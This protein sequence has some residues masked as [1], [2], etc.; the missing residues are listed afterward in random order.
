MNIWKRIKQLS[1]GQL[2][3]LTVVFVQRPLLI[4]PT[5]RATKRTMHIC[6][7]MYGRTHHKNGKANAF[8]HALWNILICQNS[9]KR[10]KNVQ[11][12]VFWAEKI[13]LLYEKVTKNDIL[14]QQMDLHNNKLGRQW[15]K[16]NMF[17]NEAKTIDFIQKC[18]RKSKKITKI[19]EIESFENTLIYISE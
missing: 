15:F 5:I 7:T 6:D 17:E 10:T 2:F 8:R 1:L 12:S 13:T 19:E 9:L 4:M 14:D 11:K 16:E 18:L 3:R